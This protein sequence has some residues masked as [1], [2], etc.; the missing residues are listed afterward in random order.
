MRFI[1]IVHRQSADH[2]ISSSASASC[3]SGYP[4]HLRV[5]WLSSSSSIISC[6]AILFNH[7]RSIQRPSY[8]LLAIMPT[9]KPVVLLTASHLTDRTPRVKVANNRCISSQN[10]DGPPSPSSPNIYSFAKSLVSTLG[11]EVRVVV[12]DCQKSWVGKAYAIG[13]IITG[14]Y[15]YPLGELA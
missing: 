4:L 11:W 8:L 13:D 5:Q 2:F 7:V 9:Y 6:I 15:F 10:D 3:L 14:K 12:P 1:I